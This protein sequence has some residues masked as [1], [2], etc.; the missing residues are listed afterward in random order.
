MKI[1]SGVRGGYRVKIA[2]WFV[3]GFSDKIATTGRST[4]LSPYPVH[5]VLVNSAAVHLWCLVEKR[6]TLAAI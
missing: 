1:G 3:Q 6:R 5:V 4:A 2:S